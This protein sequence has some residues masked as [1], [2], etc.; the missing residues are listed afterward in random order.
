MAKYLLAYHGGAM[1]GTEEEQ[2]AVMAAWGQWFGSLGPA[3]VDA[4]APVSTARTVN[5]DGS[6]SDGAGANPVTGYSVI[7]ASSLDDAAE[8]ASGCPILS[9]GG[10]VEV[11][12]TIDMS[13]AG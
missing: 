6:V 1:A 10:S 3:V 11:A 9:A 2:Q 13:G 8:K 5:A 4:G 12:E 7:E